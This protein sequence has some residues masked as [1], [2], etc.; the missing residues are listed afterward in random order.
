MGDPFLRSLAS[1]V[2][3]YSSPYCSIVKV[4]FGQ[5]SAHID[6]KNIQVEGQRC[7]NGARFATPD[8]SK[9][10]SLQCCV[11]RVE[12]ASNVLGLMS[13]HYTSIKVHR[14]LNESLLP[15][16]CRSSPRCT[17]CGNVNPVDRDG[18]QTGESKTKI[19]GRPSRAKVCEAIA[20]SKR[21]TAHQESR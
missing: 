16:V 10:V 2:S 12:D 9:T 18:G 11:S 17:V 20:F 15:S 6:E 4:K 8:S 21:A 3:E 19:H 7:L 13:F 1:R 5:E 14:H